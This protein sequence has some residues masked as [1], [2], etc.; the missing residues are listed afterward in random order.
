MVSAVRMRMRVR[1]RTETSSSTSRNSRFVRRSVGPFRGC[2]NSVR[3]SSKE[4]N[5]H[6]CQNTIRDRY[7]QLFLII[8][9]YAKVF[10]MMVFDMMVFVCSNFSLIVIERST[11]IMFGTMLISKKE[12]LL[13]TCRYCTCGLVD[14][15]GS[16][17]NR[18]N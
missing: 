14:C 18:A 11:M 5:P 8:I 16:K 4:G 12:D 2:E 3:R 13:P 7:K 17:K 1:M 10:A 6:Y 15:D 9:Y